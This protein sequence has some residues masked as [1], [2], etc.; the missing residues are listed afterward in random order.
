M[1]LVQGSK[2]IFGSSNLV[3]QLSFLTFEFDSSLGSSLTIWVRNGLFLGSS[4]GLNT[5]LRS[6]HIVKKLLFSM[7]SSILT[8][9]FDLILGSFLTFW[10][11]NGLFWGSGQG[12]KTVLGSTHVVE[13]FLFS[14]VPSILTFDFYLIFFYFEALMGY[15]WGWGWVQKLFWGLLI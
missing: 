8:F 15:F 3:E 5:V 9:D 10:G 6:S 7:F 2:T 1:R 13:Q 12:S 4:G 11:P 14:I